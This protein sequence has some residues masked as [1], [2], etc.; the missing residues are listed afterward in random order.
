MKDMLVDAMS[1]IFP[2]LSASEISYILTEAEKYT[3]LKHDAI[4]AIRELSTSTMTYE[5]CDTI[6][7]HIKMMYLEHRI[8]ELEALVKLGGLCNE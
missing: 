5:S 3:K 4:F 8:N 6:L 1:K 7:A 2:D